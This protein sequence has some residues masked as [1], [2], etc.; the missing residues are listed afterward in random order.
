MDSITS[1]FGSFVALNFDPKNHFFK[2]RNQT[3]GYI[4]ILHLHPKNHNH[5]MYS[6]LK[7]ILTALQ[8]VLGQYLPFYAI[9]GPKLLFFQ[10]MKKM[11]KT[12]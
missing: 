5:L 2:K 12:Y 6:F 3:P 10:K 7:M 1:H 8:V 4:I 9:F 11:P